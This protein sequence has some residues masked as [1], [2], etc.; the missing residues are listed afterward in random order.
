MLEQVDH[1]T[2]LTL[3]FLII[4]GAGEG[5]RTLVIIT[6]A[7]LFDNHMIQGR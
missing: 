4:S 1:F 6:K 3:K 7:V 5:N 2:A